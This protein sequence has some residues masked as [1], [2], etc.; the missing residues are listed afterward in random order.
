MTRHRWFIWGSGILAGLLLMVAF[1][2]LLL[3]SRELEQ[4][5]V[6]W[7]A[8]QGYD[9]RADRFGKA[10]PLGIT[11][12]GVTIADGRG[13]LLRLDNIRARLEIVP[14]LAGSVS[15]SVNGAVGAGQLDGHFRPGAGTGTFLA[16]EVRLE[17]IPFFRT[18]ANADVKGM[19]TLDASLTSKGRARGGEVKLA[20]RGATIR[21]AA[22]SGI[23]L[24]DATYETVRGMVR[25]SGGRATLDSFSLQ[26]DDVYVRLSGD[27]PLSA[28][29]GNSPLNLSLELMPRPAFL[30]RQKLVFTLLAKYLV[31]PGHYRLPIRGTLSR[32]LLQ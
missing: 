30:D 11:A 23:P 7:F 28:P 13:V 8:R 3:P 27:M 31:T 20:V 22:I 24:P 16:R 9:F 14:L 1:T 21:R 18:A 6:R 12:R 19:M 32:P 15:V 2:A 25:F 10:F 17:D 26:G 4:L 5:T 29:V